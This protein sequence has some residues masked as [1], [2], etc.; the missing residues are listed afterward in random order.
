LSMS[1]NTLHV[2]RYG[3]TIWASAGTINSSG[4]T[5]NYYGEGS[6][7]LQGNVQGLSQ[8][9]APP[10]SPPAPALP[11]PPAWASGGAVVL[12]QDLPTITGPARDGSEPQGWDDGEEN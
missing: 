7:V 3:S 8:G 4:D 2:S 9:S 1:G 10:G 6:L 12:K 11:M 5:V